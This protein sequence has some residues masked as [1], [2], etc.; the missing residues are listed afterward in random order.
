[1]EN[2]TSPGILIETS[3]GKTFVTDHE[4]ANAL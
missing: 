3:I 1:M 2:R 4:I